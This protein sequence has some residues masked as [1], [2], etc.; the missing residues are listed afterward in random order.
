MDALYENLF[1]LGLNKLPGVLADTL[2]VD[3]IYERAGLGLGNGGP[4]L[5]AYIWTAAIP[6]S[7]PARLY[8]ILCRLASSKQNRRQ[9]ATVPNWHTSG[10]VWIKPPRSGAV[11]TVRPS[12]LQL[13]SSE[14]TTP[15]VACPTTCMAGYVRLAAF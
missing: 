4:D 8:S 1:N 13:P 7:S 11:A 3:T 2:K 14:T 15:S 6:T 12:G 10:Q 5:A 9:L